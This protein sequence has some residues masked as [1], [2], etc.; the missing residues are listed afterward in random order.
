M[1]SFKTYIAESNTI[2]ELADH[3]KKL[4]TKLKLKGPVKTDK[5]NKMLIYTTTL[6]QQEVFDELIKAGYR[7]GSGYDP[8]PKTWNLNKDHEA[9]RTR[10]DN[11]FFG[12]SG[13]LIMASIEAE[14][15]SPLKIIFTVQ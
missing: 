8:K 3:V 12:K 1:K 5:R 11:I 7:K 15:G 9:M 10:S 14:H 13:S 2:D 4:S 6:N